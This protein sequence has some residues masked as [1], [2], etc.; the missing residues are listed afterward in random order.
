MVVA[1]LGP[2]I[3]IA[4]QVSVIEVGVMNGIFCC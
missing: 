1:T 2:Y 4:T 3:Y